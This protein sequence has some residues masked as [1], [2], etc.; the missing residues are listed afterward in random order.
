MEKEHHYSCKTGCANNRCACLR[1]N[2][3]CDEECGCVGCQNPLNGV[4]VEQKCATS[5][6]TVS[7]CRVSIVGM[8]REYS[9]GAADLG[10]GWSTTPPQ[11]V[12]LVPGPHDPR[13]PAG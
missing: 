10:G 11:A 4:D 6:P 1:N 13:R 7:R 3:P 2:E 9:I 8:M 12:G 5:A